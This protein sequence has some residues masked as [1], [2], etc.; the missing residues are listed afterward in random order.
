MNEELRKEGKAGR[1]SSR[2]VR[3][4]E[5]REAQCIS[6]AIDL[7]EKKLMDGTAGP[8]IICHYL[9]LGSEREKKE[10]E[11]LEAKRKMLDAK[12]EALES[13]KRIEEMYANAMK[14]LKDYRGEE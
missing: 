8:Q 2:P 11:I 1:K 5:N 4:P 9:K 14:A 13:T 12:T 7:A 6:L 10:M 3:L